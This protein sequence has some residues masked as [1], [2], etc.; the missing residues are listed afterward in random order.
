MDFDLS[1]DQQA[2]KDAARDFFNTRCDIRVVRRIAD[3]GTYDDALWG[4]IRR[5][6][7]T[8]V[9]IPEELGGEGL[10]YIALAVL[11]EEFGYACAPSPMLSNTAAAILIAHAGSEAQRRRWLPDLVSGEGLGAVGMVGA[12]GSALVPDADAASVIVLV[13]GDSARIVERAAADVSKVQAIDLTRP[14]FRVTAKG[15]EALEGDVA[16][17]MQR[18]EIA[19][20]A[21][22]VGVAQRALEMAVAYAQQRTQFGRPIGAYQAVSHRC[23]DMLLEVES[24]RSATY[25][26][27]WTADADPESLPLASSVAKAVA[28]DAGWHVAASSLQVHGGIAFTW[29]HDLHFFLKRGAAGARLFG[30]AAEHRDRVA[31]LGGLGAAA[32]AT[33]APRPELATV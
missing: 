14:Y 15:G 25:Y 10:G 20:S 3:A 1:S 13:D 24:A 9:A 33:V 8:G 17:A 30:S 7:W 29:E 28:A 16:G 2:I 12:D 32:D 18:V 5:L 23:A 11:M 27:A 19:L 26:A 31:G 4:D 22:L 21:E 6:G